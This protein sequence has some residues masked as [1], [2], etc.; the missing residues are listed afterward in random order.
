MAEAGIPRIGPIEIQSDFAGQV[1][2]IVDRQ[3]VVVAN[4]SNI[5][6]AE[7]AVGSERR[8]NREAG[9]LVVEIESQHHVQDQV[10]VQRLL[11]E[12][13]A[14]DIVTGNAATYLRLLD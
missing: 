13:L 8:L 5:R 11:W 4:K 12:R 6:G 14:G 10:G 3:P 2:K 9:R 1:A 7:P